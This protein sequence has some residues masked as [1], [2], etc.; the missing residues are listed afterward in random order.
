MSEIIPEDN[1]LT[2][3]NSDPRWE[4][5]LKKKNRKQ[6]RAEA[7]EMRRIKRKQG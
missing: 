7:A 1:V 4:D 6:R 2:G 5:L 3:P